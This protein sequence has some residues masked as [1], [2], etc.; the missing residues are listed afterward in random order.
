M[1]NFRLISNMIT[2]ARKSPINCQLS[3][4][5]LQNGKIIYG[6]VCNTVRNYCH[7]VV[8]SSFHAEARVML[9]HFGNLINFDRKHGWRFQ[10]QSRKKGEKV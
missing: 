8:C 3:A 4:C 7:G 5:L 1:S 6:P 10:R 9:S 2:E